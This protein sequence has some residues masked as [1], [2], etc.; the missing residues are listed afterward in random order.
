LSYSGTYYFGHVFCEMSSRGRYERLTYSHDLLH[1]HTDLVERAKRAARG[2]R[3]AF[4]EYFR[5]A[6]YPELLGDLDRGEISLAAEL[7]KNGRP[8]QD[9]IWQVINHRMFR[10]VRDIARGTAG[11]EGIE[12][13]VG[14]F[15][16]FMECGVARATGSPPTL[17]IY[18]AEAERFAPYF[19]YHVASRLAG[20]R[21]CSPL[22]EDLRQAM[23]R[24]RQVSRRQT[25]FDQA[26][27]SQ[28]LQW[29][30]RYG[31]AVRQEE[32]GQGDPR[33]QP[34]FHPS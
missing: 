16:R 6:G 20:D 27:L 30:G 11:M 10:Q 32:E 5:L 29:A 25:A 31:E 33:G 1:F 4:S 24:L 34:L 18:C 21:P 3:D 7:A 15:N 22:F 17:R 8:E 19:C 23:D 26:S 12:A 14:L 2:F 13:W 28:L 9:I